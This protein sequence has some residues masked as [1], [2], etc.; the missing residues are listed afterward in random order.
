MS[1]LT[2]TDIRFFVPA[3]D[4]AL[5]KAFYIELG[6]TE[7]WSDANLVLL[8]H[9]DQRFYLQDFYAKEFA[10]NCMIH[11]SVADAAAWHARVTALVAGG[12]FPGVRVSSPKQEAYGA[13]VTYV[14]DPSGVLLH[15]AQWANG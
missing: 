6:W 7:L 3:Q 15:F 10:E 4:F 9:S 14:W 5:S 13:L 11:I 2:I 12:Q 8:E 1:N